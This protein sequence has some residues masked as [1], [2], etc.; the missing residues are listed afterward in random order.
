M[1]FSVLRRK[2]KSPGHN[3]H[4]PRSR[5]WL[6]RGEFLLGPII[7]PGNI[8]PVLNLGPP[9][10]AQAWQRE[11]G[12]SRQCPQGQVPRPCTAVIIEGTRGPGPNSPPGSSDAAT[13][14]SARASHVLRAAARVHC[15]RHQGWQRGS[16]LPQDLGPTSGPG[17]QGLRSSVGHG[18]SFPPAV[19]PAHL[20][21]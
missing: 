20:Q 19:P 9:A 1:L 17:W 12:F 21:P 15:C 14:C 13:E 16:P 7:L 2:G 5:S 10:S 4:P 18:P 6:M 8:H 3:F 11:A